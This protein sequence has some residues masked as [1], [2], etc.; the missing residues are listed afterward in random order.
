MEGVCSLRA[1]ILGELMFQGARLFSSTIEV[2][3][4]GQDGV[5]AYKRERRPI[6]FVGWH[7]HDAIHL[8]AYRILFGRT[9]PAV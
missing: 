6:V 5:L 4:E 2:H 8:T 1:K 9:S 3:S 7:G